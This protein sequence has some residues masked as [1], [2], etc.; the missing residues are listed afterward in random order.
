MRTGRKDFKGGEKQRILSEM[1]AV[2][3]LLVLL[4]SV[5]LA[6]EPDY[7][8]DDIFQFKTYYYLHPEPE[9]LGAMLHSYLNLEIF[10]DGSLDEHDEYVVSYFFGRTARSEP[11]VVSEYI[12]F[13]KE[14]NHKQ[15]LFILKILQLCGNE[16]TKHFFE[17]NLRA[18]RFSMEESHIIQAL[19]DGIGTKF[20]PVVEPIT[21]PADL[22][23]LWMEFEATG[24]EEVVKHIIAVLHLA[25]DGR[26]LETLIGSRTKSSLAC[27]CRKHK[28]VLEICR[29]ELSNAK[30]VT[31]EILQKIVSERDSPVNVRESISEGRHQE[32]PRDVKAWA[33][34][35]VSLLWE[36]N[37]GRHD[38]LAGEAITE[39][40]M[41]VRRKFLFE[42]WG[43]D[44]RADLLD[45]L[46][47]I[48]EGGHRRRFETLGKSVCGKSNWK[49]ALVL[50][51]NVTNTE[52]LRETVFARKHYDEVGD[53]GIFGWDYSR[54][55]AL[56]RWGYSAGYISEDE[57]WRM[58]MPVAWRLQEEF[59]SWED[60]GRNY[61]MGREFWGGGADSAYKFEDAYQRLIDMP[62][63]PWNRYDW[64]M[65]LRYFSK[66][67]VKPDD[68]SDGDSLLS[69]S[70]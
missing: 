43:I 61:L 59:D 4:A 36:R 62:S 12:N 70:K 31:R 27:N 51:E 47:W 56:C 17:T 67:P 22:D 68:G 18:G 2:A 63:S 54:Y 15:R 55:I 33:L 58:I 9:R 28:R 1:V 3:I 10:T 23:F 69:E 60:L 53:K 45:S 19:R 29:K 44:S 35:C 64:Y 20:D 5:G 48:N 14:G 30:G 25:Q 11:V 37:H 40:D 16:E 65:D 52:H 42:E 39:R 26:G 46:R 13:F 66:S 21:S 6:G 57:A 49:Y 50:L 7:S 32:V 41:Q 34:S 24:S 8:I 38:S